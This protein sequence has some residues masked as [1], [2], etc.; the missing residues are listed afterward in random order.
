WKLLTELRAHDRFNRR[1]RRVE[2]HQ[3]RIREEI[4]FHVL[5]ASAVDHDRV[6][7]EG[8]LVVRRIAKAF[9]LQLRG[10]LFGRKTFR[11]RYPFRNLSAAG[12]QLT[13]NFRL[14]LMRSEA[15]FA[16]SSLSVRMSGFRIKPEELRASDDARGLELRRDAGK[17]RPARDHHVR[18][19]RGMR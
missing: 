9:A 16:G 15:E 12:L 4:A 19:R 18:C 10:D 11:Y 2:R 8:L 6:V 7:H 3:I 1:Q 14:S 13:K 17:G 5:G